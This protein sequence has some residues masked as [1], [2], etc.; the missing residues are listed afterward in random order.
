MDWVLIVIGWRTR[1]CTNLLDVRRPLNGKRVSAPDL[2]KQLSIGS[3]RKPVRETC[4]IRQT[5]FYRICRGSLSL[6]GAG[7]LQAVA[8]G[9]HVPKI[10]THEVALKGVVMEYR[11]ERRVHVTLWLSVAESRSDGSRIRHR[12]KIQG[13]NRSSESRLRRMAETAG[14]ILIDGEMF[15]EEHQLPQ[16]MDLSLAIKSSLVHLAE[17]V[18]LD[19]I[20][21]GDHPGNVLVETWRHLTAHVVSSG[22]GCPISLILATRQE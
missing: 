18:G 7:T 16:G 4:R 15:V 10:S 5:H 22:N 20:D 9:A 2:L 8:T 19:A 14:F 3:L 13:L 21:L 12:T 11:C 17:C 1:S 6:V